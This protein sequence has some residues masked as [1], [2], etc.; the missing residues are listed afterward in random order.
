MNNY[1]QIV[2]DN[3]ETACYIYSPD[4]VTHLK[5][6]PMPRR[7]ARDWVMFLNGFEPPP[8]GGLAPQQRRAG[9]DFT[10]GF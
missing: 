5:R 2:D 10:D 9:G 3:G 7:M 4:R 1:A 6:G 8:T